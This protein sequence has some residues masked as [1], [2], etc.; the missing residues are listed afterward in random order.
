MSH[1]VRDIMTTELV[2]L[3]E[4]DNLLSIREG[5]EA[6]HVRHL[7]VVDG[8]KLVGLITHRDILRLTYAELDAGDAQAERRSA[9]AEQTFVG[10]VMQREVQTV[11]PDM[12]LAKAARTL[13]K[14]K[15]GCLPVVDD[16]RLV[17]IVTPHDFLR[18]VVGEEVTGHQGE[19]S[20]ARKSRSLR[21]LTDERQE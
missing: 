8:E 9:L 15:Y 1:T 5:M 2:T 18:H 14:H 12:P 21:P 4:E 10:K 11:G 19:E 17:G 3:R 16:G 13:L 6:L 20:T 7:P